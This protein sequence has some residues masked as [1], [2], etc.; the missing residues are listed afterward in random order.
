M[1]KSREYIKK[2]VSARIDE[3]A[4]DSS[5][6]ANQL[7]IEAPIETIEEELDN[8]A[9]EVLSLAKVETLFPSIVSDK[10]FHHNTGNGSHV[11]N[12][13]LRVTKDDGSGTEA[14]FNFNSDYSGNI[15]LPP[16]FLRFVSLKM[17][18]WD[19]SVT[20]L[21]AYNSAQQKLQYNKFT[22]GNY[23]KPQAV[24]VPWGVYTS[25]AGKEDSPYTLV[26]TTSANVALSAIFG[27]QTVDGQ[28]VATGELI[29]LANQDNYDENGV[30]V[31]PAVTGLA[32]SDKIAEPFQVNST[33]EQSK[34]A[35][36]FFKSR[37]AS[38]TIEEFMYIPKL[39]AEQMP[40]E[41]IDA[42]VSFC[43]VRALRFLRQTEA[44]N[45]EYQYAFNLLGIS[46]KGLD[47]EQ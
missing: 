30:Y 39:K 37:S 16:D 44:A 1:A 40:D 42:M 7:G 3:V 2:L 26:E 10:K 13:V 28:A 46:K 34:A 14:A 11:A 47:G 38:A 18:D 22:N 8:A 9:R 24:L 20:E 25:G 17:S 4:T 23:S 43:A 5:A 33:L 12:L 35:I 32:V 45:N 21:L 27:G 29:Y 15:P 19:R 36:R 6:S 31:V 41:L